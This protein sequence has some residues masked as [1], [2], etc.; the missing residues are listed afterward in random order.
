MN[1][2]T[3]E[4]EWIWL[5]NNAIY[6]DKLIP[7][8]SSRFP[9]ELGLNSADEYKDYLR[10]ILTTTGKWA[11]EKVAPRGRRLDREGAGELIDGVT[12]PGSALRELYKEASELAVF[13]PSIPVEFGGPEMIVSSALF[14]HAQV[15]RAC[16]ASSTQLGFFSC[17]ADMVHRFCDQKTRDR[18]LPNIL[19]GKLSGA[20]CMT[21]PAC[22]SDLAQIKTSAILQNDGSYQ[23]SGTKIFITNAG[24]GINFTLARVKGAAE[25][26]AGISL[27][28]VEQHVDGKLNF[29][30]TKNEEKMGLHGSFTCE[31]L[32]ENSKAQLIGK[33]NEGLKLMFHLM[34]EARLATSLQALGGIEACIQYAREYAESRT[35]F[36][37]K[38]LELPLFARNFH[39]IEVERDALRAVV[40][41]S[42]NWFDIYQKLDL[43]SRHTNDLTE[44]ETKLL[45]EALRYSRK[46]TPLLKYWGTETYTRISK[47]VIQMLGGHG[48]M[49]DHPVEQWHRDSFA[50][51]L[52]EGTSQIQALMA[53]KDI[54][55]YALQDPKKYFGK[56]FFQNTLTSTIQ[57]EK[58]WHKECTRVE[59]RFKAQLGKL[60]FKSL[61]PNKKEIFNPKSCMQEE[62]VQKVLVHAETVCQ[63]LYMM[64]TLKVL[65]DHCDKDKSREAL[66]VNYLGL[67]APRFEYIYKDWE[68]RTKNI[69]S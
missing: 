56:L 24:G 16:I 67:C 40:V 68:I 17:I 57:R 64:E 55:K 3:D 32:Y 23:I 25:G 41:D 46:R 65:A 11:S 47:E 49:K 69:E 6:W 61:R 38:L 7:L 15:A 19:N 42:L 37:K 35:A 27:F 53:L 21:E 8:Y 36:G 50:P 33:E 39:D 9:N 59:F 12:V 31:V 51:L 28:L 13:G 52:Y 18:L 5:F 60:L 20:M 44:S 30:V 4:K 58:S 34:N 54:I 66:F 2:F 63:G 43:K 62:N 10:D 1:Y 26:L 14:I 48:L 45:K 29:R 22:G